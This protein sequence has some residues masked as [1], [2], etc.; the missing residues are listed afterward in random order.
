[1][2][3]LAGIVTEN[4]LYEEEEPNFSG[5]SVLDDEIKKALTDAAEEEGALEEVIG[6]TVAAFVIAVPGIVNAISKIVKTIIA[7]APPAFKIKKKDDDPSKLDYLI[8]LTGEL[9][10]YLD[11]PFKLMLKPFIQDVTK[12]EKFAKYLKAITLIIMS[13]GVDISKSPDLMA[14]GKELAPEF[15]TE[16]LSSRGVPD[17]ITKL[18]VVIPKLFK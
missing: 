16:L 11:T 9:D 8:K 15:F 18:K 1:M 17:L 13:F 3:T 2:Q 10:D 5:L 14:F 12:R 4:V 6:L 7:K